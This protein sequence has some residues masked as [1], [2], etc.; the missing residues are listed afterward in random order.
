MVLR[1]GFETNPKTGRCRAIT[2]V[3]GGE[4]KTTRLDVDDLVVK[5]FPESFCK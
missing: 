4:T 3:S 5:D 2:P 1:V